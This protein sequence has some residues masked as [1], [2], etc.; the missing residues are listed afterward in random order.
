MQPQ[1]FIKKVFGAP[2][3]PKAEEPLLAPD[4]DSLAAKRKAKRDARK[5]QG[6]GRASTVLTESDTLG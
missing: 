1:K 3:V 4:P 2:D 5:R 6:G